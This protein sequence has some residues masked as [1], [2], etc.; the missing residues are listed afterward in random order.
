[1]CEQKAAAI[2]G[3]TRQM[4][5]R[6]VAPCRGADGACGAV[7]KPPGG[8]DSYMTA[9]KC[10]ALH[11]TEALVDSPREVHVCRPFVV[12]AAHASKIELNA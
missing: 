7:G 11:R 1:M 5:V 3:A 6:N 8:L 12:H 2:E 9:Y 10:A 4:I